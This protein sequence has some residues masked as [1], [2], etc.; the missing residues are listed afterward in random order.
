MSCRLLGYSLILCRNHNW[1]CSLISE[2]SIITDKYWFVFNLGSIYCNLSNVISKLGMA[3]RF[4]LSLL[5]LLLEITRVHH[6][7]RHF[8]FIWHHSFLLLKFSFNGKGWILR[9]ARF[10]SR[11]TCKSSHLSLIVKCN[12]CWFRK[13]FYLLRYFF[14]SF[15]TLLA[16]AIIHALVVMTW[17]VFELSLPDSAQ[18]IP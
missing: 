14:D 2:T 3:I 10:I 11:R 16:K 7:N 6:L 1:R 13:F 12:I 8:L 5:S 17:Y 4:L 15:G 9:S 18:I